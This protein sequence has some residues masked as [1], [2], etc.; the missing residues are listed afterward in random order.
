MIAESMSITVDGTTKAVQAFPVRFASGLGAYS[1]VADWT[2]S[3]GAR[4]VVEVER[5]P[6]E[7]PRAVAIVTPRRKRG[8]ALDAA[9]IA[10]GTAAGT[11]SGWASSHRML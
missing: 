9:A 1:F 2:T 10:A 11:L 7:Q 6:G 8:P 3:R 4:R 5:W